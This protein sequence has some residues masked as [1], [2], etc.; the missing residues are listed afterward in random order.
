MEQLDILIACANRGCLAC[1][2]ELER[3]KK[4]WGI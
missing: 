4:L 3:L 1:K 2:L